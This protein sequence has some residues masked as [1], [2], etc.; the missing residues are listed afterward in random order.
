MKS[1]PSPIDLAFV[2]ILKTADTLVNEVTGVLK[3][4]GL[5]ATQYNVLRILRGA[6]PDSLTC[7]Q[8]AERM[9]TRDPDIT[10]LMDRMERQDLITRKRDSADRRHVSIGITATGLK[11]LKELDEP[12]HTLHRRQFSRL[13]AQEL[14]SLTD[15]LELVRHDSNP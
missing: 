5:T 13:G 8:M 6:H 3:P 9:M 7:G 11:L 4:A 10:R 14:K 1:K 15:L 2:Q 12:I